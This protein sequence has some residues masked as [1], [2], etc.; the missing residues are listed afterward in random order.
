V[1]ATG[2][3][4]RA[5]DAVAE[6][7]ARGYASWPRLREHPNPRA[8]VI[9]T[10]LNA[11]RSGW[12]RLRRELLGPVPDRGVAD[13]GPLHAHLDAAVVA[14][15]RALPRRQR[16][17]V[18]LRLLA[19]LDAEETGAILG[20]APATVHVHLHRAMAT[21]RRELGP[22]EPEPPG[23]ATAVTLPEPAP[24]RA[25]VLDILESSLRAVRHAV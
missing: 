19:D 16:E 25:A 6:A 10:A 13:L 8:W 7:Y 12:R 21:L 1:A 9:R 23:G 24:P 5:E 15:V 11:Y 3:Y 20:I 4:S 22:P 17:V 18:A 2:S 14:A